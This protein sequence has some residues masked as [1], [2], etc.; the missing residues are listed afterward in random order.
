[1]KKLTLLLL[2]TLSAL[3]AQALDFVEPFRSGPAAADVQFA[4]WALRDNN[5]FYQPEKKRNYTGALINIIRLFKLRP[6]ERTAEFKAQGVPQHQLIDYEQ[7]IQDFGPTAQHIIGT[8][9]EKQLVN[10]DHLRQIKL[11]LEKEYETDTPVIA[12]INELLT[13]K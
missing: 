8:G 7:A 10:E 11:A 3:N 2:I 1:M 12:W 9:F 6:E 5:P 4:Q 13:H